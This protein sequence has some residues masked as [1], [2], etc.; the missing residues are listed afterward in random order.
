[1]SENI[2]LVT[3]SPDIWCAGITI[4]SYVLK[5]NQMLQIENL[6]IEILFRISKISQKVDR[7]EMKSSWNSKKLEI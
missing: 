5:R 7:E 1:M 4:F 3:G 6:E 2:Y